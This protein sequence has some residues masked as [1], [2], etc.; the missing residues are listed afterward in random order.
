[1][2]A[3][4]QVIGGLMMLFGAAITAVFGGGAIAILV[5]QFTLVMQGRPQVGG[6][7]EALLVAPSVG[8][9]PALLGLVLARKGWRRIR[10]PPESPDAAPT[11]LGDAP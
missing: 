11:D 1:M 2:R 10:P 7:M 8:G 6:L 3:A 4:D 9:A 5:H